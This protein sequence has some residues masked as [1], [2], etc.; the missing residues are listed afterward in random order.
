[1]LTVYCFWIIR[2]NKRVVYS[3][4]FF[5][6]ISKVWR[7][8]QDQ[9]KQDI[10]LELAALSCFHIVHLTTSYWLVEKRA[11]SSWKLK[12][13]VAR[14]AVTHRDAG[15]MRPYVYT[16]F[17]IWPKSQTSTRRIRSYCRR[18]RSHLPNEAQRRAP[19][20]RSPSRFTRGDDS[21]KRLCHKCAHMIRAC[22]SADAQI[23]NNI[24]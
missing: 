3:F 5:I 2:Y 14:F 22:K 12:I 9:T 24:D 18:C 10:Y 20:E 16:H 19:V 6:N 17:V 13:D 15:R 4:V 11:S 23:E 7:L 8:H 21:R 1:M